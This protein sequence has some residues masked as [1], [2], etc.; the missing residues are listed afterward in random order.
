MWRLFSSTSGS[1]CLTRWRLSSCSPS[2][3]TL[4]ACFF[5]SAAAVASCCSVA[6]SRSRRSFWNSASRFLL[7]SSC[8]EVAPP[9]SSS[10]SLS[11]SSSRDSSERCFST[12][13]R[14]VLSASSSSSS[15]SIRACTP[16]SLGHFNPA[17]LDPTQLAGDH[18]GQPNLLETQPSPT[19][20]RLFN[21][22]KTNPAKASACSSSILLFCWWISN[23]FLWKKRGQVHPDLLLLFQGAFKL[24]RNTE[25]GRNLK[26]CSSL[27]Q[28]FLSRAWGGTSHTHIVHLLFQLD[29]AL[30]QGVDLVFLSLQVVQCL[31]VGFLQSLLL[32]GQFGDGLVQPRHLLCQVLDLWEKCPASRSVPVACFSFSTLARVSS[33]SSMSFFSSEHSS[34]SFLFLAV[35][36]AFIS[37]SSS[38]RS[39]SS[40]T[41]ASSWILFLISWSQRSSASF[42]LSCSCFGVDSN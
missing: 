4:S 15:S 30:S 40:F 39:V 7:S 32:L 12:L 35:S 17:Q 6:S 31:L 38:S 5:L 18:S 11:S 24:Y 16:R 14:P 22:T 28:K 9:A 25:M 29:F 19:S 13:A 41:L 21:P 3:A 33:R 36:S 27:P 26:F 1:F 8:A 42:R 34:S 2:S 20:Q 23:S 10:R 37:S